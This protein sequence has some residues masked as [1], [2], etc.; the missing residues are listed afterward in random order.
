MYQSWAHDLN[1]ST[2]QLRFI[3]TF[4]HH[5]LIL[6]LNDTLSVCFPQSVGGLHFGKGGC[7]L[8]WLLSACCCVMLLSIVVEKLRVVMAVACRK[9]G[10]RSSCLLLSLVESIIS[11]LH[12][13]TFNIL[14]MFFCFHPDLPLSNDSRHDAFDMGKWVMIGALWYVLLCWDGRISEFLGSYRLTHCR[15]LHE[16]ARNTMYYFDHTAGSC[17][18]H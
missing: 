14:F 5:L 8:T 11:L 4:F 6:L 1:P 12:F 15:C 16:W 10:W 13:V 17:T 7:S 3:S 18:L 9:G 2:F